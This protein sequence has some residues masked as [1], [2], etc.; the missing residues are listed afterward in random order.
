MV[1]TKQPDAS[2]ILKPLKTYKKK[3][4]ER[5]SRRYATTGHRSSSFT[6]LSSLVISLESG[7]ALVVLL[8]LFAQTSAK[9]AALP[10]F[11]FRWKRKMQLWIREKKNGANWYKT[12]KLLKK[13]K[14]MKTNS[15]STFIFSYRYS[16]FRRVF[17]FFAVTATARTAATCASQWPVKSR[18]RENDGSQ[19]V[20]TSKKK[21][22]RIEEEKRRKKKRHP[23]ARPSPLTSHPKLPSNL[24]FFT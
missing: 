8:L 23:A 18:Q 2:H 17:I 7:A 4:K 11:M 6:L 20:K 9:C 10:L 15:S 14:M 19:E 1:F 24:F 5:K 16:R 21:S 3:R 22:E 12:R 13:K